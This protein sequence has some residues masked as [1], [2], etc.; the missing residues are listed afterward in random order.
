MI[1][2]ARYKRSHMRWRNWDEHTL[3]GRCADDILMITP[4]HEFH[5]NSKHAKLSL[6]AE[7]EIFQIFVAFADPSNSFKRQTSYWLSDHASNSHVL[8]NIYFH[9]L[10][11]M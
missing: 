9:F 7:I 2:D 1:S 11:H 6:F 8:L 4:K 3:Y 10:W 5:L